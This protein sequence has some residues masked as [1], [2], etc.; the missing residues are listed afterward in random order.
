MDW[1][2]AHRS[3]VFVGNSSENLE[4]YETDYEQS[5]RSTTQLITPEDN[6]N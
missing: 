6:L 4:A 1:L 2:S 5:V 3:F